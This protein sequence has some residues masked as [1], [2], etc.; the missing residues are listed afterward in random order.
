[1]KVTLGTQKDKC[2]FVAHGP[3]YCRWLKRV[4]HRAMRRLGKRLGDDAPKKGR[5]RG[6]A[7]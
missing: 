7:S 2:N 6:W 3:A 5:Y 4:A 1:M